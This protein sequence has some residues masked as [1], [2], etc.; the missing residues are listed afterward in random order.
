MEA[1]TVVGSVSLGSVAFLLL[2]YGEVRLLHAF[3]RG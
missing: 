3:S 1:L 2:V